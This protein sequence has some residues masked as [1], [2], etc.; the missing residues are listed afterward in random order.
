MTLFE[1]IRIILTLVICF[2]AIVSKAQSWTGIAARDEM[3]KCSQISK[4]ADSNFVALWILSS[5]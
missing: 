3:I 1:K 4:L 2:G 5:K